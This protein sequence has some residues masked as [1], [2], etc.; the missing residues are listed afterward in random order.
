MST[1]IKRDL[2]VIIIAVFGLAIVAELFVP[3]STLTDYK[4]FMGTLTSIIY[5]AAF[6]IGW[7]YGISAEYQMI[8]RNRNWQQYFVSA[9]FF[10][11]LILQ[12][13]IVFFY[14]FPNTVVT[15]E[16]RWAMLNIY[17]WQSQAQYGI[18]FLYQCGAVYRVLRLRSMETI[19]LA[20]AALAFIFRSIPLFSSIPGIMEFGDWVSGAPVLAGTRAATMTSSIGALVVGLRSLVGKES[21]VIE[22]R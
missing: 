8:R 5:Y 12:S 19:V 1:F 13:Y 11:M 20:I 2:P 18:M 14:N 9:G 17:Q 3:Y 4:T 15:P 16:Y 10:G 22:V 21:T 7:F 6:G